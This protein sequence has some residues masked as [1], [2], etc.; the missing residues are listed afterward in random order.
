[1]TSSKITNSLEKGV[2]FVGRVLEKLIGQAKKAKEK[3]TPDAAF[4]LQPILAL[5][6]RLPAPK[7]RQ[8]IDLVGDRFMMQMLPVLK[9]KNVLELGENPLRFQ[10]A[11]LE[12]KPKFFF[13]V[14]V[15]AVPQS[16]ATTSPQA[17]VLK[18]S[19]KSIPFENGFFDCVIAQIATPHQGD[20]V[21]AFK[22]IG[23]V[24]APGGT[25]LL[26]D[27][28]PFGLYAKSGTQRLRSIQ[29]TIRGLE[30]YYKMCR[31]SSLFITDMHEGFIDDTLRN[32]FATPDE[33]S[34]YRE[35]KG[36]PLVLFLQMAKK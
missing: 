15:D 25:A 6:S 21:S 34:A 35:I 33:M 31:V 12:K 20:V 14:T 9:D 32:Q 10:K 3:V 18:G 30:D 17:L 22:E 11:I 1:M 28:H 23:R 24:L 13:G 27:Y 16:S 4:G 26:F 36:T 29:A 5:E 19:L 8:L 7:I 2:G